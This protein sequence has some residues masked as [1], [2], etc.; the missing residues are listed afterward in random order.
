MA[1]LIGFLAIYALVMAWFFIA[2]VRWTIR[3]ERGGCA[4]RGSLGSAQFA[5]THGPQMCYP[6]AEALHPLT[7]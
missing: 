6:A 1:A 7:R 5:F 4:C 2:L 3:N